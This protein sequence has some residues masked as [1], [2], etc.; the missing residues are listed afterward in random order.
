MPVAVRVETS[1]RVMM[2]NSSSSVLANLI[3][4]SVLVWLQQY[5]LKQSS[6]SDQEYALYAVLMTLMIFLPL[7][8]TLMTGGLG[9]YVVE[10]YVQHDDRRVSEI[11][12]TLTPP[13]FG[14]SV[15]ILLAGGFV[16][17]HL[18]WIFTDEQKLL[19]DA[20]WMLWLLLISAVT[21]LQLTPFSVGLYVRQRFITINLLTLL[22]QLIRMTL[23]LALLF[24]VS[25]RM[26]WV[27]V[28]TVGARMIVL[29]IT[30]LL[31]RRSVPALRFDRRLINYRSIGSVASYNTWNFFGHLSGLLVF[32]VDPWLLHAYATPNDVACLNVGH[33]AYDRL[34]SSSVVATQAVQPTLTAMH[35]TGEKQRL[36]NAFLRGSR[37]GL[38]I[39]CLFALPI[40]IFHRDLILLYLG[41]EYIST[42]T[43]LLLIFA[44][45]PLY[46]STLLLPRIAEATAK[47][48]HMTIIGV[49][50]NAFNIALSFYLI[51]YLHYGAS[52]AAAARIAA[53]IV[54]QPFL[55]PLALRLA[56]VS[57]ACWLRETV[58]RG[59]LPGA[60]A[61]IA[62]L[63]W[64]A[65]V[66]PTTWLSLG[67]CVAAGMVVYL[68]VLFAFC[69]ESF[70][71]HDLRKLL[72]H[73]GVARPV[74]EALE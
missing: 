31:S 15:L 57:G 14:M 33:L 73:F 28:A 27:V 55:I 17:W 56:N 36:A 39:I 22:T 13:L 5:L 51:R 21:H 41:Q 16:T 63:G 3:N 66:K 19:G 10:A 52:G 34:D 49:A 32:A 65:V 9:R 2:V 64:E 30:V 53:A 38:W 70:E 29:V 26:L 40:M 8:S 4:I 11:V 1:K 50:V 59:L 47:V 58:V 48:A 74:P 72:T 7:L 6:I 44:Q 69:L 71:R 12:S 20:R 24:G 54:A 23:L 43:V 60:A 61:S 37:Y 62:W 67:M 18:D 42:G 68:V 35:T 46:Y 25:S 45:F